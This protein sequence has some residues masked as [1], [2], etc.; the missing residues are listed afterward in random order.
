MSTN[1]AQVTVLSVLH[2]NTLNT[3][4]KG[5]TDIDPILQMKKLRHR[6]VKQFIMAI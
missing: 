4:Y 2:I 1:C 5:G 3:V 6:A